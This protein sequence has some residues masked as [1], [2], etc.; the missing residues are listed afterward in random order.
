MSTTRRLFVKKAIAA[1]SGSVAIACLPP[2][3]FAGCSSN[4][5]SYAFNND[6]IVNIEDWKLGDCELKQASLRV[7]GNY[8]IL[9]SQVCTHFTHT[10]D[11]WHFT[12]QIF[13]RD[14]ANPSKEIVV[15]TGK[16]DGP[17]MSEQDKPLFHTWNARF[18]FNAT[19]VKGRRFAVNITSCC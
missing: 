8:I 1:T 2:I 16:L 13:Y 12:A 3:A 17:Q 10:K 7:S 5:R 4:T 15:T 14:N 6:G 11:V 19:A 9:N 18:A